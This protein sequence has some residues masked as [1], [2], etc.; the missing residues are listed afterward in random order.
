[1]DGRV[2]VI[3]A[4]H[5]RCPICRGLY[6]DRRAARRW[7]A[8]GWTPLFVPGDVVVDVR[9]EC[10]RMDEH[11][12]AGRYD[13]PD[14]RC[15]E[16][17]FCAVHG[18]DPEGDPWIDKRGEWLHGAPGIAPFFVVGAVTADRADRH[19]PVY[20]LFSEA[21]ATGG[22]GISGSTTRNHIIFKLPAVP[23]PPEVVGAGRKD[24]GRSV[25]FLL[26]TA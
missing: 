10:L 15:R 22:G 23:P 1:M 9:S 4:V 7:L 17:P 11:T 14:S 6:P 25:G 3:R 2:Q 19:K 20:H 24:V 12:G 8:R 16:E 5:Y 18:V 21:G 26:H 13:H